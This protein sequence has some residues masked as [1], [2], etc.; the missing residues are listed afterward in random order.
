MV[1]ATKNP[2]ERVLRRDH[3][4]PVDRLRHLILQN[5]GD[6]GAAETPV[7]MAPRRG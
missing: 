5:A 2:D 4:R 6:R 7:A 3:I 1:A